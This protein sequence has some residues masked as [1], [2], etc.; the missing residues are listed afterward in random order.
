[1]PCDLTCNTKSFP[2]SVCKD[3]LVTKN[4]KGAGG[5]KRSLYRT[6]LLKLC[7]IISLFPDI[8]KKAKNKIGIIAQGRYFML[9]LKFMAFP[10]GIGCNVFAFWSIE[11]TS[12][13]DW[14][15][16]FDN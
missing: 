14:F 12:N 9:P 6:T 16:S 10:N 11:A 4:E 7:V 1:M 8:K 2:C 5:E 3:G 13:S 15:L